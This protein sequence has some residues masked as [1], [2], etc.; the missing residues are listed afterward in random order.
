MNNYITFRLTTGKTEGTWELPQGVALKGGIEKFINYFPGSS[1]YFV[2][3]NINTIYKAEKPVFE[4]NDILNDPACE[5][6]V[7]KTNKVLVDY[8]KAHN[9]YNVFYK[10]HDPEAIAEEKSKQYDKIGEAFE[11]ISKEI[12]DIKIQAMAVSILGNDYIN[13]ST[14]ICKAALKEMATRNPELIINSYNNENY[15]SKFLAA[16]AFKTKVVKLS[17]GGLAV[18]WNDNSES[19]I[20]NLAVGQD[21]QSQLANLLNQNSRENSSLLQ[22]M[23]EKVDSIVKATDVVLNSGKLDT[24]LLSKIDEKDSEIKDLKKQLEEALKS[25]PIEIIN[26]TENTQSENTQ[27]GVIGI[28]YSED[29]DLEYLQQEYVKNTGKDLPPKQKNDKTWLVSKLQTN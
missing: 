9:Y 25:K 8:L 11:I 16:L 6:K 29:M 21:G 20:V 7:S 10:I 15:Y 27:S 19:V 17:D 26:P 13:E 23:Q 4:Y 28:K 14:S 2:E 5:I 22:A 18:L 3:D 24:E 12:T 1:S